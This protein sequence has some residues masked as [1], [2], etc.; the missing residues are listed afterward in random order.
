MAINKHT[1]LLLAS[2]LIIS[3]SVLAAPAKTAAALTG[4]NWIKGDA[5]ATF[6]PGHVY[7]VE[8]WATWCPPCKK[9][10][11]H[12]TELQKKYNDKKVSVISIS[13]EDVKTVKP[14]VDKMGDKM[15]YTIATDPKWLAHKNYMQAF[16]LENIPQAFIVDGNGKIVWQG[17]PMGNMDKILDLVLEGDYDPVAYEKKKAEEA[18]L[19]KQLMAWLND[20]FTKVHAGEP[21]ET[22]RPIIQQFMEKA[23]ADGL[24]AIAWNMMTRI[25]KEN[26]DLEIA[27]TAS[28][29]AVKLTEEKDFSS[30]DLHAAILFEMGRPD[31]AASAEQKAYDLLADKPDIQKQV[32]ETLE[33]YK[34]A[35]EAKSAKKEVKEEKTPAQ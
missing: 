34:A 28:E 22:T 31:E 33:K 7:I 12:L 29:K 35:A 20:Y 6:K 13:T 5:V 24:N 1:C 26:Q 18:A 19:Q 32:A 8:F 4:L 27:L 3:T 14:F 25:P 16:N 30:L 2:L 11:P 10:I 17:H 21:T 15:A 9:S 23:D